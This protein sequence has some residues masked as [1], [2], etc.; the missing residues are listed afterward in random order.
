MIEN[1]T[2]EEVEEVLSEPVQLVEKNNINLFFGDNWYKKNSDKILG[3]PY[4]SSGKYGKVTK[5]RG[6][7]DVLDLIDADE[8]F[9]G[10]NKALNDPLASVSHDMNISAEILKPEMNE[11]VKDKYGENKI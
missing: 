7:I 10:A 2:L 4:E 11:F 5:Y 6:D 1:I 9:I 3:I 8:N